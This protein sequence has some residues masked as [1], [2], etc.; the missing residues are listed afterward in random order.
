MLYRLRMVIDIDIKL[1]ALGK[2]LV[3]YIICDDF[4][5]YDSLFSLGI[6]N[7]LIYWWMQVDLSNLQ[8]LV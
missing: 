5:F 7:V 6:S 4:L 2:K 3:R 1:G 8:I